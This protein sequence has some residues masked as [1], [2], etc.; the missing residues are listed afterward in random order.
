MGWQRHPPKDVAT[1]YASFV[2]NP[3]PTEEWSYY[4]D[5]RLVGVGYVDAVP[6]LGLSAIYFFH[7]PD[8][9]ERGLGTWNI[10][11]VIDE[12]SAAAVSVCVPRLLSCPVSLLEYKAQVPAA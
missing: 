12:A 6:G 3:F 11:N 10:L 5:G 1:Y 4:L 8:E 7:D 2:D 9:R